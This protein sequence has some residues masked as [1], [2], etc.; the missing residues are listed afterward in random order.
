MTTILIIEDNEGIRE[1]TAELL[2]LLHYKTLVA[3]NGS[4]GFQL[5]Q[6][7]HPDL[8]LCDM[9]M[10]ETDGRMFLKL[11]KEDLEV[12]HIPLIFFSAGSPSPDDQKYLMKQAKG[13]LAKPFS[14][15]QLKAEIE[16][17]LNH[18]G[19]HR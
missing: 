14:E 13:Y 4:E 2:E 17:G 7:N 3:C 8:I 19:D 12:Q 16:K 5:A 10:P 11:A 15:E 6:K 1:N 9:V 18:N